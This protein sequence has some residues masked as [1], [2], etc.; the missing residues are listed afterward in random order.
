MR[1]LR[2]ISLISA[3][4]IMLS[5]SSFAAPPV[6]TAQPQDYF[7]PAGTDFSS[8]HPAIFSVMATG[9]NLSY[10]WQ[11]LYPDGTWNNL[12]YPGSNSPTMTAQIYSSSINGQRLIRCFISNDEGS[13]I[14]NVV[15]VSV[16][17]YI[18]DTIPQMLSWSSTIIE[19]IFVWI[20]SACAIVIDT[21][22]LLIGVSI[23]ALG[24]SIA[25]LSRL[26]SRS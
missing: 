4:A 25:I 13:V 20:G 19:S 16:G 9:E 3:L 2:F 15:T 5:V 8:P 12:N 11:M 10:Q 18:M 7:F 21:P 1:I 26:L 17:A 6:I 22:L 24:A 23:F 14:S